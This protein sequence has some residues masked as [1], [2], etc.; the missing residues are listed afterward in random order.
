MSMDSEPSAGASSPKLRMMQLLMRLYPY[1][2]LLWVI[3]VGG[4]YYLLSE[5]LVRQTSIESA[6]SF[7]GAL[8]DLDRSPSLEDALRQSSGGAARLYDRGDPAVKEAEDNLSRNP[9]EAFKRFTRLDGR[10]VLKFAVPWRDGRILELVQPVERSQGLTYTTLVSTIAIAVVFLA[11]LGVVLRHQHTT[12]CDLDR[13]ARDLDSH[14]QELDLMVRG[15]TGKVESLLSVVSRAATADLCGEVEFRG[16]DAIGRLAAGIQDM[17]ESLRTLLHQ[18]KEMGI[19]VASNTTQIA[20]TAREHEA[21]TGEHAATTL[22]MATTAR[23]ISATAQ[24]LGHTMA[25]ATLMAEKA[26]ELASRGRESMEQME[27][28]MQDMADSSSSVVSKLA[29]INDKA[30]SITTIVTTINKVA[31]QT[32]L[33]SLNAAIEAEKAGEYGRG[34][35]VVSTEIRRLAD[36]TAV[37]T[38]DIEHMIGEMQAAVSAGV[39]G[40]DQFTQKV[41]Q[42]VEEVGGVARQIREVILNVQEMSPRF[43]S[44]N[45][46]MQ[47]QMEAAGHISQA[48]AELG[49]MAQRTVESIQEAN[50]AIAQLNGTV[51]RMQERVSI[52]KVPER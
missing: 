48:M 8:A 41:R 14:K 34:F 52:F 19:H 28:T 17:I 51:V 46:G 22:E 37:A 36:Q 6:E 39:M 49:D 33:L 30:S 4:L 24:E 31:D 44:V 16:D 50:H 38:L 29:A 35:S 25:E 9:G 32:N 26:A 7:A 21:S 3:F 43:E 20:A 45:Q 13:T 42:A 2:A 1:L 40:M 12:F 11:G 47:A 27:K 15:L 23:E 10:P 5:S 18:I